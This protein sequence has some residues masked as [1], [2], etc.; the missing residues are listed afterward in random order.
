MKPACI[1]QWDATNRRHLQQERVIAFAMLTNQGT[2]HFAQHTLRPNA[3]RVR[4]TPQSGQTAEEVER[5]NGL[6][7]GWAEKAHAIIENSVIR[8][9]D[10]ID[11]HR[12]I[13]HTCFNKRFYS[14]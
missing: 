10:T 1:A 6:G 4:H 3:A 7:D 12:R 14:L 5:T 2:V 13:A 9:A 11:M 8:I